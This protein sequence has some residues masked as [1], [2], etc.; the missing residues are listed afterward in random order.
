MFAT[1]SVETTSADSEKFVKVLKFGLKKNL[2]SSIWK[3]Q[4]LC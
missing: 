4:E 3:L 2:S 1:V